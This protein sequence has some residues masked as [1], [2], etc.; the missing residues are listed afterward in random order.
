MILIDNK[1][2]IELENKGAHWFVVSAYTV[3]DDNT[4]TLEAMEDYEAVYHLINSGLTASQL[5][6]DTVTNLRESNEDL[7]LD[8]FYM[9]ELKTLYSTA[10]QVSTLNGVVLKAGAYSY[11]S[12]LTPELNGAM[13][14]IKLAVAWG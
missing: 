9:L 12:K 8:D 2:L 5:S 4:V 11:I 3:T 14:E 10:V 13:C 7:T 1:Y 6:D